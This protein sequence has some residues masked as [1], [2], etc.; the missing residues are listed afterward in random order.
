VTNNSSP[1]ET[2]RVRN[3][4][5]VHRMGMVWNDLDKGNEYGILKVEC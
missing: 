3:V 2:I 4:T 1:S 5:Q